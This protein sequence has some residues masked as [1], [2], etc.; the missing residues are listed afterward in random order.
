MRLDGCEVF[1]LAKGDLADAYLT[2]VFQRFTQNHISV[3]GILAWSQIIRGVKKHGVD[4]IH[5]DKIRDRNILRR[6]SRR[7]RKVL[8]VQGDV[9]V[10]RVFV[11]LHQIVIRNFLATDLTDANVVD[12]SHVLF[13]QVV[14]VQSLT[15]G[16]GINSNGNVS[17]TKTDF[18]VP[19]CSHLSAS[20]GVVLRNTYA[21]RTTRVQAIG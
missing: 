3:I 14:K 2:G 12:P 8:L 7:V 21:T 17:H 11:A 15:P 19:N 10:L 5:V 1:A 13:V 18:A 9:F 6:L 20:N 4:F 16:S